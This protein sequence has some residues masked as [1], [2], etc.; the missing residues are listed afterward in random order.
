MGMFHLCE[1]PLNKK[2]APSIHKASNWGSTNQDVTP[3]KVFP[4]AEQE[5][6]R[7]LILQDSN[8][9]FSTLLFLLDFEPGDTKI[10]ELYSN[11]VELFFSF[12]CRLDNGG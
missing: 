3:G 11:W 12:P 2:S 6:M 1:E 8:V 4:S 5:W 7:L 9:N 10:T